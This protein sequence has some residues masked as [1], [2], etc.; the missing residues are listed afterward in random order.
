MLA[1]LAPPALAAEQDAEW[2]P[3]HKLVLQI[4]DSNPEKMTSVL[5]V[6]ANVSRHYSEIGEEVEIRIVAFNDGLDMLR[7]D[8]SPVLDRLKSFEQS[9]PNVR[10]N[11][12]GNTIDSITR[13]EGKAPPIVESATTVQ[14]A[15]VT[16]IELSE[17]GWT[18]VRP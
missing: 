7:A 5:N 13:A 10:F 18:I 6:A 11:A 8:R 3:V 12:C 17:D 16:L 15:V 4:S 9:M 14:A 2:G 1:P